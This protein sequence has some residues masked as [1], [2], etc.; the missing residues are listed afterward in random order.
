MADISATIVNSSAAYLKTHQGAADVRLT[1][2]YYIG[3]SPNDFWQL[4]K[5]RVMALVVFTA[6]VGLLR[7]PGELPLFLAC[8]AIVCIALGAGAAG[9][10]NMA[11]DADI[12]KLMKR[13][14]KRPTVTGAISL[15]ATY[16]FASVLSVGAVIV[17]GLAVNWWAAG[18]LAFT[19]WFYAVLYTV[20]LKRSTPHNIV[21]GGAA[22]AFPPAIGWLAMSG[23]LSLEPI[24]LF[25]IIFLWTPPHFWALA[26]LKMDDYGAAGVPM[27]PNVA[28][29]NATKNQILGYSFV[30]SAAAIAPPILHMTGLFYAGVSAISSLVFVALAYKIFAAKTDDALK[31]ACKK[32]F[33]YSIFYLFLLFLA[34]LF[35]VYLPAPFGR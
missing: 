19:I 30:L 22:G 23:Q 11:Y 35:D 5:P 15:A 9:A 2:A 24:L 18:F 28:G 8:L 14:A 20:W 4:L 27:L 32:L 16:G 21:I 13:T 17:L 33:L 34:L 31:P 25:L 7:A 3:A 12:D 10:F 1:D 26:I 6:V 29:V